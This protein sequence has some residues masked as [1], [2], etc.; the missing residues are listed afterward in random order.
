MT[1][2][3]VVHSPKRKIQHTKN[4]ANFFMSTKYGAEKKVCHTSDYFHSI[5]ALNDNTRQL[6]K[7]HD[8]HVI[9]S[10]VGK[11]YILCKIHLIVVFL[12]VLYARLI[13]SH[14]ICKQAR[15]RKCF[16]SYFEN[17]N[18]HWL[19]FCLSATPRIR[20]PSLS[21]FD[22]NLYIAALHT[23]LFCYIADFSEFLNSLP[24]RWNLSNTGWGV[25]FDLSNFKTQNAGNSIVVNGTCR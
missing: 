19:E 6:M 16:V 18:F 22:A 23:L 9:G 8:S 11:Q 2:V 24:N 4:G 25:G 3:F 5:L 14:F 7:R 21:T 12:F 10:F 13:W 15:W 17:S 20:S 1:E